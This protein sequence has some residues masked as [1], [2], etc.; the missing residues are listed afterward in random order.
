M[1]KILFISI[2]F[3]S[4]F[5]INLA[6]AATLS[7][8]PDSGSYPVGQ[9]FTINILLDTSGQSIDGTDIHYLNYNPNQLEIQDD[10]DIQPGV[11][12][13]AGNLM[14]STQAN[15]VDI[16]NGK[17]IFSQITTGGNT[18]KS[19]G[20]EVLATIHFKVLKDQTT[21]IFFDFKP[22]DTS[23]S[24]VASRGI[25]IL[26]SVTNAIYNNSVANTIG[27]QPTDTT[28]FLII[29]I[30]LIVIVALFILLRG[31]LKS[32]KKN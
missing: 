27:V 10:N 32:L 30:I 26:T 25:D 8:S 16:N 22:E 7:L 14:P 11:Q 17:I 28:P 23:D 9:I 20:A 6:N 21:K 15:S 24:N 2:L 12:I 5:S 18:F 31:L 3:L 4:V 13:T 1:K 19:N 29:F